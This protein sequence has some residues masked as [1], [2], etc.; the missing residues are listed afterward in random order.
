MTYTPHEPEAYWMR[1]LSEIK[2]DTSTPPSTRDRQILLWK[3]A[4]TVCEYRDYVNGEK[5]EIPDL[6]ELRDTIIELVDKERAAPIVSLARTIF[7]GLLKREEPHTPSTFETFYYAFTH[8]MYHAFSELDNGIFLRKLEK[9]RKTHGP[10]QDNILTCL[11]EADGTPLTAKEINEKLLKKS[12]DFVP[13]LQNILTALGKLR[14][15]GFVKGDGDPLRFSIIRGESLDEDER[16]SPVNL[17]KNR[18]K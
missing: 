1:T 13:T 6:E 14:S 12:L 9:E 17:V 3:I 10:L 16:S 4:K 11:R 8:D 5:E 7:G 15:K 18:L 2:E